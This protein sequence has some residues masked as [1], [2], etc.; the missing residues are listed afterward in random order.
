[1]FKKQAVISKNKGSILD[2][3]QDSACC[4]LYVFAHCWPSRTS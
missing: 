4:S 2:H 1:M 3:Y